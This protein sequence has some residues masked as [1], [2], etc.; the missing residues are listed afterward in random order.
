[1]GLECPHPPTIRRMEFPI[2]DDSTI[3]LDAPVLPA[4]EVFVSG[5][6]SEAGPMGRPDPNS[7]VVVAAEAA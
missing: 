6:E 2:D 5:S 3:D 4:Y 7:A 1:M